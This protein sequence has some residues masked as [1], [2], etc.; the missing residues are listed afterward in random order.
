MVKGLGAMLT[1]YPVLVLHMTQMQT[2]S[3]S[4]DAKA[5]GFLT[6]LHRKD[7]IETAHLMTDVLM[8]LRKLSL[9]AQTSTATLADMQSLM[10]PVVQMLEM[11]KEQSTRKE[12]LPQYMDAYHHK[13]LTC[14]GLAEQ[15]RMQGFMQR[16][17]GPS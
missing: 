7:I 10:A 6:I 9:L 14:A 15:T 17:V 4:G 12:R 2:A 16:A 13:Q 5:M 3:R 1:G 11:F 8:V